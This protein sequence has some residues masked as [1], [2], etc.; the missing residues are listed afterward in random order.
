MSLLAGLVSTSRRVASAPARRAK[1]R[2]LAGFL[3]TLPPDE[4]ETAVHFLSGEISQ[5]KIGIAYKTLYAAAESQAAG[6]ALL[7]IAETD[8]SLAAIA[9]I[10]GPGSAARRE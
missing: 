6:E 4:I 7:S 2:E 5:G 3:K 8:R 1:V 10:R 9:D